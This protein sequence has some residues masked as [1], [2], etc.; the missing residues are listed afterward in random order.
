MSSS[1]VM[2]AVSQLLMVDGTDQEIERRSTIILAGII[3]VMTAAPTD[4]GIAIS[5]RL[6]QIDI[7]IV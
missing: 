4:T 5:F 7:I 1:L 2:E 6:H 3:I